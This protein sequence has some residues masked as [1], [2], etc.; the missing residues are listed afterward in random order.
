MRRNRKKRSRYSSGLSFYE[1]KKTVNLHAIR[2]GLLWILTTVLAIALAFLCWQGFGKRVCVTGS[3][4]DPEIVSGQ[5]VLI[6]RL[7]YQF[8][9]P[10][11]GDVIAFY[12]G[13]DENLQPS[14]K[15]VVAIPG[16]TVQIS[17]GVLLVNGIPSALQESY[18]SIDE[19]GI[20]SGEIELGDEEYFVLGD[21][22]SMSEDSRSAGIGTVSLSDIIGEIWVVL[23]T[24]D[25]DWHF[26]E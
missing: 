16:D 10:E 25:A 4:M 23:P 12:P 21:N 3:S 18:S 13:G 24:Q 26:V 2:E 9:D 22:P 11:R 1:D 20:A 7:A 19:A 8:A 17:D 6:N 15:R 14:V 5:S